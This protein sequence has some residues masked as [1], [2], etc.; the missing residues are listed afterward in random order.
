MRCT[1]SFPP[2]IKIAK[3]PN[4]YLAGLIEVELKKHLAD[5]TNWRNM[6]LN[7][8]DKSI[9]LINEKNKINK[10]ISEQL[11][12]YLIADNQ[13]IEINYPIS[14]SHIKLKS[15]NLDKD[16][17]IEGNKIRIY[18]K[19][20]DG[21]YTKGD[22]LTYFEIAG[23]DRVFYKAKAEIQ[24]NTVVNWRATTGTYD[25]GIK[26]EDN[27]LETGTI[28]VKDNIFAN[29]YDGFDVV[30]G[31]TFTNTYNCLY[32]ITNNYVGSA[33]SGTGEITSDPLFADETNRDYHLK[34]Q[35]GRY[36]G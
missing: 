29:G 28:T 30:A 6:L 23:E 4:R 34:S 10:L 19:Y 16:Y 27:N 21:L 12:S 8:Y 33:S 1:N 22:E 2:A 11:K 25:T 36:N 15:L 13:I 9:D 24:N 26:V 17:K 18:F 31:V 7:K 32:N 14:S 20:A 35:A 5:K 3:T